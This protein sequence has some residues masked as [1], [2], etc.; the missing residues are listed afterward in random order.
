MGYVG[1]PL[2]IALDR[3]GF[4]AIGVR[5][6][7]AKIESPPGGTSYV[8]DI[9]DDDVARGRHPLHG[10]PPRP[11]READVIVIA[12]PT[13]LT[14]GM[15]DLGDGARRVLHG[16]RGAPAPGMLVILESTT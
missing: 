15:P 8:T 9:A 6:E 1:L 5:R 10:D 2:A 13:P 7:R 14:D 16:G 11:L 12:V 4:A 3:A